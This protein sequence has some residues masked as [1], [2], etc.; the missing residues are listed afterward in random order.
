MKGPAMKGAIIGTFYNGAYFGLKEYV[1][2]GE[3]LSAR[4]QFVTGL[5]TG[6]GIGLI[7]QSISSGITSGIFIGSI[8]GLATLFKYSQDVKVGRVNR[9]YVYNQTETAMYKNLE[10]MP[11]EKVFEPNSARETTKITIIQE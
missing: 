10:P 5:S 1:N 11:L 3:D 8:L 2:N 4:Q 7:R 9:D 6:V